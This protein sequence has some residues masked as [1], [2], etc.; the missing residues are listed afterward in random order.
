[1]RTQFLRAVAGVSSVAVAALALAGSAPA[2]TAPRK[3]A[4]TCIDTNRIQSKHV[5]APDTIEFRMT[6]GQVYRNKVTTVCPRLAELERFDIIQYELYQGS[7][8]CGGDRFRVFE[9]YAARAT[10]LQ[11]FPYCRFGDFVRVDPPRK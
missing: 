2:D 8:V 9:P 10:G 4:S 3:R 7:R 6:G 11:S 1:M 5:V